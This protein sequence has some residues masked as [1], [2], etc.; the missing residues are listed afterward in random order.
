[1]TPPPWTV[2]NDQELVSTVSNPFGSL[3][4]GGNAYWTQDATARAA[5]KEVA[6]ADLQGSGK[7]PDGN[8]G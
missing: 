2:G 4:M 1:M 6:Q 7:Q 8:L 5:P 3:E